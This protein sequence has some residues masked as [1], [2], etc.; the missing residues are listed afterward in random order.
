MKKR[1]DLKYENNR[2]NAVTELDEMELKA[3]K[4]AWKSVSHLC[5]TSILLAHGPQQPGGDKC[6]NYV[7]NNVAK[8]LKDG[9]VNGVAN[10]ASCLAQ[11]STDTRRKKNNKLIQLASFR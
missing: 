6:G 11:K 9:Y 4:S 10:K 8:S 7:H 5:Q 2:D 1:S 3:F